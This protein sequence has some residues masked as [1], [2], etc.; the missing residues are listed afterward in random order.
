MNSHKRTQR[1]QKVDTF[2]TSLPFPVYRVLLCSFVA[3]KFY[4]TMTTAAAKIC[5]LTP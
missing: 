3:N 5:K 2:Q 4:K 1:T